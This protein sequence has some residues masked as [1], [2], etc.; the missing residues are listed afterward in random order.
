L[1][2]S[3]GQ[4]RTISYM[5]QKDLGTFAKVVLPGKVDNSSSLTNRSSGTNPAMNVIVVSIVF[6]S[7]SIRISNEQ[8]CYEKQDFDRQQT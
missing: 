8:V 4:G 6:D 3:V 7:W 1:F 5:E 2:D